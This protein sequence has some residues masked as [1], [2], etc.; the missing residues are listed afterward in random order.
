MYLRR[1]RM[2]GLGDRRR[3]VAKEVSDMI[4]NND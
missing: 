4:Y 3:G 1:L 2:I